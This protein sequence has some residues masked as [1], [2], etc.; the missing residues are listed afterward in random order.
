MRKA[1]VDPLI[2]LYAWLNRHKVFE[3]PVLRSL[4]V[5]SYFYYKRHFEDPFFQLVSAR[6]GL[7][8]HGHLLDVG[9]NIGY[10]SVVFAAAIK[11]GDKVFAFEPEKRNFDRL[12]EN[13]SR[14]GVSDRVI[15]HCVAV[16][17]EDGTVDIWLN[18][19][20]PGDHRTVTG[21][22]RDRLEAGNSVRR[23]PVVS[24]DSF[25]E[26]NHLENQIGFIKIDV[27]G[28]ETEVCRGMERTLVA[29]PAAVV[30]IEYAPGPMAE[31]GFVGE[32][33]VEF[34]VQR[35]F[36]LYELGRGGRLRLLPG[37]QVQVDRDGWTNLLC[38]REQL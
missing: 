33:L 7:F 29:S 21:A 32:A 10:T 34:F 5:H 4:L 23:V 28:Y 19:N 25:V 37:G 15:A 18:E 27:Q 3:T 36:N 11:G 17:A 12:A 20:H 38:S 16:G 31:L 22:F 2:S 9:A 13:L 30:A 1:L 24:I 8:T 35:D 6:P 26:S 14:F